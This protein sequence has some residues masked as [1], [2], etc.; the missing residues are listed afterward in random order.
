IKNGLITP[1]YVDMLEFLMEIAEKLFYEN[2]DKIKF[3]REEI[4]K[5]IYRSGIW[6]LEI[7]NAIR[8]NNYDNINKRAY[9]NKFFKFLS[10]FFDYRIKKEILKR[11][12][13]FKFLKFE[14][15][16]DVKKDVIVSFHSDFSNASVN[17]PFGK[18]ITNDSKIENEKIIEF[19]VDFGIFKKKLK[20]FI[21][22]FNEDELVDYFENWFHIH[23]FYDNKVIEIIAY[24]IPIPKFI[25]KLFLNIRYRR[26][27]DAISKYIFKRF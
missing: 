6:Y 8:F 12:I 24:K 21:I 4:R 11:T 3:L 5:A 16:F 20:L 9:V 23:R 22:E 18:I 7:L 1:N 27:K 15:K 2:V 14:E 26:L 13:K 19:I 10:L 25:M 17:L